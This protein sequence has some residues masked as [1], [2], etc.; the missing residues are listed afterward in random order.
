VACGS[1]GMEVGCLETEMGAMGRLFVH[2]ACEGALTRL[3]TD[4]IDLFTLR[5][6]VQV[7]FEG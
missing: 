3:D 5:G 4:S 6:P 7:G 1:D 2:E